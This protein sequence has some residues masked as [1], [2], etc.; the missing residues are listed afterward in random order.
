MSEDQF[1][2]LFKYMQKGFADVGTKFEKIESKFDKRF[3]L[4]TNLIDGYAG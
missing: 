3:D 2:K 1:I 4:L